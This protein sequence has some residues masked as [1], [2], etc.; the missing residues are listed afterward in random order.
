MRAG[1]AWAVFGVVVAD[2][3]TDAAPAAEKSTTEPFKTF[4]ELTEHVV[5][6][7]STEQAT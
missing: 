4:P 5:F 2:T 3:V 7:A 1:A 6:G